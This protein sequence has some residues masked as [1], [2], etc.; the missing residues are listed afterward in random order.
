[1][2]A[3]LRGIGAAL[4]ALGDRLRAAWTAL[5]GDQG[6]PSV[7]LWLLLGLAALLILLALLRLR[8]PR[9][10]AVRPPQLLVTQGEVVPDEVTTPS[11]AVRRS[12][13]PT[14][15]V[16]LS[17]S[18]VL[19]MTVSNMSR[20]PVQLLEAA[21]RP[22]AKGAP[23]V[24]DLGAVVPAMASA[25]IEA[26]L[27]MALS[28]DGVMDVYCYAAAPKHKL[29]R[30]RVELVWEPWAERFKVAPM[31]Q[32]A[33]PVKRLA[34]DEA[35]A[36][37]QMPAAPRS[38]REAQDRAADQREAALSDAAASYA[39]TRP[40]GA[41]AWRAEQRKPP[42]RDAVVRD[43]RL[44]EPRLLGTKA[45][46]SDAMWGSTRPASVGPRG[47]EAPAAAPDLPRLDR[48]QVV[49]SETTVAFPRP[50]LVAAKIGPAVLTPR[51]AE[52]S[53][54]SEPKVEPKP[55]ERQVTEAEA[56]KQE[57]AKPEA[58][59][60]E[61]AEPEVA[62]RNLAGSEVTKPQAAKPKLVEP[63]PQP[64]PDR[65]VPRRSRLEFPED[66]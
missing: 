41:D 37:F 23:T 35:Q 31:E 33:D 54:E 39:T 57:V 24:V 9:R 16:F 46:A 19:S 10:L 49:G 38:V 17:P 15:D 48:S 5:S 32:R 8:R 61:A 6:E 3:A 65:T 43:A 45:A 29:Y 1:M 26:R 51:Q 30:H 2:E 63:R 12:R 53:P 56:V 18:G 20:Y 22:T 62:E 36:R 25:E 44:G 27:P 7:L 59:K 55:V 66:F 40:R 4:Q 28:T 50:G 52:R 58:A 34:S 64:E 13:E 42:S 21:L 60:P 11:L 47:A 14:G